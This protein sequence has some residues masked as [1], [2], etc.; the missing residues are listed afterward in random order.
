MM[1]TEQSDTKARVQRIKQEIDK[2]TGEQS[3]ALQLAVY[4]GMSRDEVKQYD[5][6][7]EEIKKLVA[8]LANLC[9]NQ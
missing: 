8:E 7:L 6:R 1:S 4:V 9:E 2:L 5:E 3:K